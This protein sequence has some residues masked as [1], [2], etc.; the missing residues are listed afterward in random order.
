MRDTVFRILLFKFF[1]KIQTWELLQEMHGELTA[2]RFDP[3]RFGRTLNR[4][5]ESGARIYSAAYIMPSGPVS[6]RKDRKHSMHLGLLQRILTERI[7]EQLAD[8]PTMAQAYEL[9]LNLPSIGPFLAY[10]FVTDI[11]YSGHFSFSE[12]EFVVPG[13]GA[14]D[15][16]RK[17]FMSLGDFSEADTIRWVAEHQGEEF[18]SRGLKFASLW[19]RPLQLIDCQNVF[20]EVDKYA[21]VVHPEVAGYS[22]R[23]RIKQ[24][25]APDLSPMQPWFPPKWSINE[26]IP[27]IAQPTKGPSLL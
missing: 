24:K 21:R 3:V 22:G 6:V 2:K 27:R 16:M 17:C 12:M 26:Q 25:F 14:R 11:N 18:L 15:G 19:G 1:N 13:P 8:A 7:P 20:C 5:F 23:T 10:Q 4:A 9:L